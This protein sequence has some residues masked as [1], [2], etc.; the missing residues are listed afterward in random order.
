MNVADFYECLWDFTKSRVLTVA[1]QTGILTRL[2][3]SAATTEEVSRDLGLDDLAT[4][5]LVRALCSLGVVAA[6]GKHY[7]VVDE[8]KPHLLPG[9][10][11]LTPFV[12]HA[13]GL[14]E[15]WGATLEE[16]VRTGTQPKRVRT[17]DQ[18][19]KFG[20]GMR[21]SAG[22]MAPQ[23]IR[24]LDGFAGIRKVLDVGGGI[25][26]YAR[27]FCRAK[28][29]LEVT[30]LDT[31]EVADLG[32]KSL[33]KEKFEGRIGF[34]GGDYHETDFGSPQHSEG[35]PKKQRRKQRR[36]YDLVLLANVLHIESPE[37]AATLI[38]RSA[39]AC[40]PNGR[41]AVVDFTIDDAKREN[42]MG[43]LFAINTRSFGDTHSGPQIKGWMTAAGLS[44]LRTFDL[45][46]AHWM[47]VGR[48]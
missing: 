35:G 5:K 21:A 16:W 36:S 44:D 32:R 9:E 3:G 34:I 47:I 23:V 41:V 33:E 6:D 4:G 13:H 42:V 19:L 8:L 25:G 45:P 24:A 37:D 27:F 48:A 1:S 43:C 26:G 20:Q 30:I 31:P 38:Q 15:R 7:R 39:D 40:S 14:Y 11:D 22:L 17:G 29:D 46:P 10:S 28:K 18:L 2:A 12:D